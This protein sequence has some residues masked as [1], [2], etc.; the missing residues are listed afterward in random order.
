MKKYILILILSL[1]F[2][3]IKAQEGTTF[4]INYLPAM[5]LGETAEF[6][7]NIS[8]RGV[9]FEMNKYISED[10]SVGFGIGWHIFR[11]KISGESFE[12]DDLLI[13]GTQF[14]YT[15]LTPIN[16]NVKKFFSGNSSYLPYIG[17]GIGT[18]Y[19]KQTN[20]VGV[21]RLEDD[22]WLFNVAPEL[23][24]HYD[25]NYRTLISFKV[26]YSYNLKA[27]DFPSQS[28]LAIGIG[29]GFK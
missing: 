9:E 26:K 3:T 18:S 4:F 17:A 11:E 5:S 29:V 2:Q 22:K 12:Y 20:E 21:F 13:T 14:R 27:G 19:A 10:L 24:L 8:P 23:G 6:T 15:N 16:V 7:D 28:F 25:M 1:A